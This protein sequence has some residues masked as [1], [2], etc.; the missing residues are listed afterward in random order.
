MVVCFWPVSF[1]ATKTAD[2]GKKQKKIIKYFI[3]RSPSATGSGMRR[4]QTQNQLS[5]AQNVFLGQTW[6]PYTPD[7]QQIMIFSIEQN[8]GNTQR[9]VSKYRPQ[10]ISLWNDL[11]PKLLNG[12]QI[13]FVDI[14][15]FEKVDKSYGK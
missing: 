15:F 2:T 7:D 4:Q 6:Q 11:I 10:Q 14:K 13:R 9:S 3:Y 5:K 8:D 1:F 12:L